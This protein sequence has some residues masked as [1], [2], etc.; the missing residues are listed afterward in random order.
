MVEITYV[1]IDMIFAFYG[2]GDFF[3]KC[4]VGCSSMIVCTHAVLGVSYACFVFALV[5]RN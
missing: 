4:L 5:Q 3:L 1:Y 2:Y